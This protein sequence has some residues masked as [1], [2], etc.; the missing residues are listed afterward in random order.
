M[1]TETEEESYR[2][3]YPMVHVGI[4]GRQKEVRQMHVKGQRTDSLYI[5]RHYTFHTPRFDDTM[6]CCPNQHI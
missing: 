2:G 4:S 1:V 5:S 6:V 3:R